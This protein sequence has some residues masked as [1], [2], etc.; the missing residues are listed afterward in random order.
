M[1]AQPSPRPNLSRGPACGLLAAIILLIGSFPA[2]AQSGPSAV[3]CVGSERKTLES[4]N[5]VRRVITEDVAVVYRVG[6]G[7]DDREGMEQSLLGE[8]GDPAEVSCT[9]SDPGDNYTGLLLAPLFR[10]A[11]C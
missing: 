7:D 5:P 11:R 4:S 3:V 2:A 1:S 8:L 10:S 9:W 6:V